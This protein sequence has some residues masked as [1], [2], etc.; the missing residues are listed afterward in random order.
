MVNED[1]H[2]IILVNEAH[3][4]VKRHI[5]K[6]KSTI[7]TLKWCVYIYGYTKMNTDWIYGRIYGRIY[8]YI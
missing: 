1:L 8:V 5:T 6:E 7:P 3:T 4:Q 2:C